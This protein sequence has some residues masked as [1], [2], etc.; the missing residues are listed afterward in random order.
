M[1]VLFNN[2]TEFVSE[3]QYD[4]AAQRV[5][6]EVVRLCCLVNRSATLPI[7]RYSVV[8]AYYNFNDVVE[9]LVDCGDCM[10]GIDQAKDGKANA[11]EVM[12][13]L[14]KILDEDMQLV[15]KPGRFMAL[16]SSNI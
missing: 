6:D 8:A 7:C 11:K 4:Q 13:Q 3:L 15:V 2:V 1:K 10:I 12:D 14:R 9:L 5:R 16:C